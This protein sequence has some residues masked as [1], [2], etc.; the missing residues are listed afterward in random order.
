M[1]PALAEVPRFARHRWPKQLAPLS[2][3]AGNIHNEFVRVWLQTLPTKNYG[4]VERFNHTYP[5]RFLPVTCPFR[6]IEIGA[7]IGTHLTY[8]DLSIQEYHCIELRE[9]VASELRNHFPGVA[10]SVAD[11]QERLPY[12]DSHFDRAVVVHVLEHLPDLPKAVTELRRVLKPGALFS[13][14][15]PCDPGLAYEVARKISAERVFRKRFSMPYRWIARREHLNS[16]AE[17]LSVMRD[18]F[19]EID[20]E[21]YPLRWL[22][23]I[24]LNLII[25][26]TYRRT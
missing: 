1:K 9:N 21:Y 3:E 20:R 5:L 8:E 11:C 23:V 13:V 12:P 2:P 18:G 7:G 6:T 26:V 24:N 19:H 25:G 10:V 16:P 4:I 15:L 14:L 22:P 17:I